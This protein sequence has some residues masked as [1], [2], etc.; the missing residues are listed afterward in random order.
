MAKLSAEKLQKLQL[1]VVVKMTHQGGAP[2]IFEYD[3]GIGLWLIV[4]RFVVVR[5]A[6]VRFW[7]WLRLL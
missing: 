3:C 4:C 7:Q 5:V 1:K 6:K 2:L